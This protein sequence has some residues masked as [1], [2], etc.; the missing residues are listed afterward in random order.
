MKTQMTEISGTPAGM[1]ATAGISAMFPYAVAAIGKSIFGA[2]D[3][4]LIIVTKFG[5]ASNTGQTITYPRGAL[6]KLP[7]LR[8]QPAAHALWR[9][10]L[11]LPGR[12]HG[13]AQCGHGLADHCGRRVRGHELR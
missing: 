6:S 11:H 9:H 1:L 13:A 2:A 4:P 5:G 7:Q 8:L 12:S 10:H 3:L